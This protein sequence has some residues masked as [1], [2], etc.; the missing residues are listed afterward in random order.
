MVYKTHMM[1]LHFLTRY[2]GLQVIEMAVFLMQLKDTCTE[3][4]GDRHNI[5]KKRLL[6]YFHSA[7]S[8]SK[9]AIEM[10][11]SISQVEALASEEL[12]Q[13]LSW[14]SFVNWNGGIGNNIEG[15]KVQE[16]CNCTTKSVVQGMGAN[17]TANAIVTASQA[18]PGVQQIKTRFD[19]LNKVH[20]QSQAHS[21]RS[22]HDDEK[23]MFKD[24]RKSR[25]FQVRANRSHESFS[26]IEISP[27][28]ALDM[29][30]FFSRLEKHK[31]QISMG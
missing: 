4:D 7:S 30:K 6:S 31:K 3:G 13:R 14:G 17:K 12:A 18:A 10:F 2:Y 11:T 5:N 22:S 28:I 20:P 9:Y 24:L 16:I 25:P 15:E 26:N 29:E 19:H 8:F 23:L 27:L 21:T 1:Y